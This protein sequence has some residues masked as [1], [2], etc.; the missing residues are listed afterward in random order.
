[1]P[2]AEQ[3]QILVSNVI[4]PITEKPL[5]ELRMVRDTFVNGN[6]ARVRIELPTPAYPDGKKL[7]ELIRQRIKFAAPELE[8]ELSCIRPCEEKMRVVVSA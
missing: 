4:E 3:L 8:P 2:T 7:E 1:M 6:D 5:G